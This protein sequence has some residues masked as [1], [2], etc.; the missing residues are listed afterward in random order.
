MKQYWALAVLTVLAAATITQPTQCLRVP[1]GYVI[2]HTAVDDTPYML[3]VRFYG[4]GYKEYK[5]RQA[6]PQK[7]TSAG[8]FL[9]NVDILVPPDDDGRAVDQDH[10]AKRYY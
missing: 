9:P 7:L 1:P 8:V 2:Y 4:D 5:L 3:A 6:N 10:L